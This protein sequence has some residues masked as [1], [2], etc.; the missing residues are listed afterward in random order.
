MER[1]ACPQWLY[2]CVSGVIVWKGRGP[3]IRK[4][5]DCHPNAESGPPEQCLLGFYQNCGVGR[6]I[7]SWSKGAFTENPVT[8]RGFGTMQETW[9][10]YRANGDFVNIYGNDMVT[11][12]VWPVRTWSRSPAI[13]VT[14]GVN[15]VAEIR[16]CN[17]TNGWSC[18]CTRVLDG[19]RPLYHVQTGENT[20]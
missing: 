17:G 20:P 8:N 18:M 12:P 19:V 6:L 13:N 14:V 4:I 7:G 5:V 9:A 3:P 11:W 10:V 2:S 16:C 1:R 15:L